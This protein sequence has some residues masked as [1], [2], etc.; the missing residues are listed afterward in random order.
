MVM[1]R[2]E[3]AGKLPENQDATKQFAIDQAKRFL[4]AAGVKDPGPK[5]ATR[6]T[7]SSKNEAIVTTELDLDA[8]WQRQGQNFLRLGYHIERGHDDTDE[9]K[10][11][12]LDSLPK[13]GPQPEAYKGR[14]DV[15]LLVETIPW[16]RQAELAGI[17]ISDYL[18]SRINQTREWEGNRF[19]TPEGPFTAWF[20]QWGQIFTKK[21]RPSGARKQL[22]SDLVGGSPFDGI[23]QEIHHPEVTVSGKYFDLIG[24]SVGSVS[25]PCLRRWNVR[26]RLHAHWGYDAHPYFRPLVHGSEIVTR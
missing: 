12:Y 25:V 24:Y 14:L 19:Q 15:P 10:Q 1:E 17:T 7:R 9:G 5:E 11:A 2:L 26:P 3:A 18:K 23:A 6:N 21:I 16:E 20:N 8:E 4:R 13:F 22:A